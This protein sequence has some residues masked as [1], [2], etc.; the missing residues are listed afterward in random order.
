MAF[1]PVD[2]SYGERLEPAAVD[3]GDWVVF[4]LVRALNTVASL[5]DVEQTCRTACVA[6]P[7][8]LRLLFVAK[9]VPERNMSQNT[10]WIGSRAGCDAM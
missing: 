9:S 2:L 3:V 7:S 8:G 5:S 1:G 6:M 4:R 10:A